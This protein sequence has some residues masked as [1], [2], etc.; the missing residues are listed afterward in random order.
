MSYLTDEDHSI[1]LKPPLITEFQL[2]LGDGTEVNIPCTEISHL[3]GITVLAAAIHHLIQRV[4]DL[5]ANRDEHM[6]KVYPQL[7][8]DTGVWPMTPEEKE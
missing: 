1:A 3:D 2:T 5:E 8:P 4:A 6:R 7:F